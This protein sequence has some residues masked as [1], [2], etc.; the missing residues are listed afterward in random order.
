MTNTFS[1]CLCFKWGSSRRKD[2]FLAVM[3]LFGAGAVYLVLPRVLPES[4]F[5]LFAMSSLAVLGFLF[6]LL[7][8]ALI[9]LT[10][11]VCKCLR[12]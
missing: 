4:F 8:F 9:V 1:G 10:D 12:K 2:S 7:L 6:G 5:V 3:L 11:K